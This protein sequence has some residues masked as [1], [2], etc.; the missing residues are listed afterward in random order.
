MSILGCACF[1]DSRD[2]YFGMGAFSG[3]Q[4]YKTKELTTHM[5]RQYIAPSR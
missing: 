4:R 3:L 5:N 2:A 1:K